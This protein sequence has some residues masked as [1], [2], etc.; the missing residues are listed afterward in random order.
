MQILKGSTS[1]LA[2]RGEK[3]IFTSSLLLEIVSCQCHMSIYANKTEEK[4]K[5]VTWVIIPNQCM[6]GFL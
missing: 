2:L 6:F 1:K 5:S 4:Y 3:T